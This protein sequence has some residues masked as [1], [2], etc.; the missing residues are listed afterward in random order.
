MRREM[1]QH[2]VDGLIEF[3]FVLL[4]IVAQ[5]VTGHTA[6]HELL[7][8]RIVEVQNRGANGII[9]H[10]RGGFTHTSPAPASHTVIKG[11]VFLLVTSAANGGDSDVSTVVY[12][13][14]TFRLQCMVNRILNSVLPQGVGS[15]NL[16]PIVKYDIG[17]S[18]RDG[19]SRSSHPAPGRL[20]LTSAGWRGLSKKRGVLS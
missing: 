9:F 3:L 2:L 5:R 1:L 12:S 18:L 10:L 19:R 6:P 4:R 7:V 16:F 15:L 13:L 14:S 20:Q 11:L 8:V 17:K